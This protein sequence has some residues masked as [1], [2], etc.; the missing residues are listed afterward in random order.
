M[1]PAAIPILLKI[2]IAVSSY[3]PAISL[4]LRILKAEKTATTKAVRIGRR[5]KNNPMSRSH[6]TMAVLGVMLL[7][8]ACGSVTCQSAEA[9]SRQA[10]A[11]SPRNIILI[12]ADDLG[13]H[14]LSAYGCDEFQTPNL[15]RLARSGM[16][17]TQCHAL[18]C[19]PPSCV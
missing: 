13:Y 7:A 17:F 9:V 19:I 12:M 6:H 5:E 1:M 15:D 3:T 18:S 4:N 2:A 10:R 8:G 16:V 11:A 14:S